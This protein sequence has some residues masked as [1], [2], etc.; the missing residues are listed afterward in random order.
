MISASVTY[1]GGRFPHRYNKS[2]SRGTV[3]AS[4]PLPPPLGAGT[5]APAAPPTV[6]FNYMAHEEDWRG[7]RAAVRIAR[8]LVA[9]P[10]FDGIVGP[11]ISPGVAAQSDAE[12]DGFLREHLESAYV[13]RSRF[14]YDLGEGYLWRRALFS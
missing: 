11:E 14:T 2:P 13:L 12:L 7:F 1:D 3:R 4:A 5:A 9:Q 8:E 6:R 10:A